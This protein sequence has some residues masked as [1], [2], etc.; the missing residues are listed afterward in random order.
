MKAK[1]AEHEDA[2]DKPFRQ[3]DLEVYVASGREVI[4]SH[5]HE[6]AT[7][8]YDAKTFVH[9]TTFVY[10]PIMTATHSSW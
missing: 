6:A 3:T 10:L 7:Y 9:C 8:F 5:D 4:T 2:I 1:K